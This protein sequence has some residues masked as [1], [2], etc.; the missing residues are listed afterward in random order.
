MQDSEPGVLKGRRVAADCIAGRQAQAQ[1][2]EFFNPDGD[3][4]GWHILE[5][6]MVAA[7]GSALE[8]LIAKE[9]QH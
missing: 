8:P 4:I 2:K 3:D 9:T 6:I 5:V 1:G 7:G